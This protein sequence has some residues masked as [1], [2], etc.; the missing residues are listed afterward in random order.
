MMNSSVK[1]STIMNSSVKNSINM[2]SSV[3]NSTIMPE[4]KNA[5]R[6]NY[7]VKEFPFLHFFPHKIS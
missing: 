2:N 3:K 7:R 4:L 5:S 6:I 1:N